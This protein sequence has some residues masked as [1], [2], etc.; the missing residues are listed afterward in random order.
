[1]HL[2]YASLE[3]TV[4]AAIEAIRLVIQIPLRIERRTQVF[5]FPIFYQAGE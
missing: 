4:M 2:I 3:I 1:M 5:I